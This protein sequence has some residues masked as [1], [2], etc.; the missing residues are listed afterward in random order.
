M[1][2]GEPSLASNSATCL[3]CPASDKQIR[4]RQTAPPPVARR[5]RESPRLFPNTA[6]LQSR[7]RSI[8][9]AATA[10]FP[11]DAQLDVRQRIGLLGQC[12]GRHSDPRQNRPAGKRAIRLQQIDRNRRAQ[13]DD[14]RRPVGLPAA[15]WPQPPPA[16]DRSPRATVPRLESRAAR[17]DTSTGESANRRPARSAQSAIVATSSSPAPSMHAANEPVRVGRQMFFAPGF[18]LLQS[19]ILP[20]RARSAAR[21][22]VV[23]SGKCALSPPPPHG[24]LPLRMPLSSNCPSF[25]RLLPMSTATKLAAACGCF[26]MRGAAECDVEHRVSRICRRTVSRIGAMPTSARAQIHALTQQVQD[27][28]ANAPRFE[29]RDS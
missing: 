28:F 4:S 5:A 29:V 21:S 26:E 2:H 27:L 18:K 14:D 13:I 8:C 15:D 20:F 1:S 22:V 7:P 9:P 24:P 11:N 3:R 17:R 6:P 10:A 12:A 25:I 16:T 19:R 23:G